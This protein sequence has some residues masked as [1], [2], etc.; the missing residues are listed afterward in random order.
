MQP[1]FAINK[2][3]IQAGQKVKGIDT[4]A[5]IIGF[6]EKHVSQIFVVIDYVY[7]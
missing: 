2:I 4:I 7:L 6:R 1:T 3:L 5:I